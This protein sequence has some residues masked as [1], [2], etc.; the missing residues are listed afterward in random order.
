MEFN[1]PISSRKASRLIR[2]LDLAEGSRVVDAGCGEG[3]FLIRVMEITGAAGLGVDIDAG[4]LAAACSKAEARV[5]PGGWEF[6]AWD[7]QKEALEDGAFDAA[8]CL[9][10]T[11][12]FGDGEAAYPNAIARLARAVR[13]GG[14]VLIGEGY[15]KSPPAPEYLELIGEPVGI[16]RDHAENIWFAEQQGLVPLYAAVSNDDEWDHFEWM[17]RMR[18]ERE[19]NSR[20]DDAEVAGKLRQSRVWRDGYLRWGRSTMGFGFYLFTRP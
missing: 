17:H 19:S 7:L 12:A 15:W 1:I 18:I 14:Q 9:G 5:P 13:P 10:S 16:Y 20:P 2:L 3:E 6:R 8:I 4:S 11:H